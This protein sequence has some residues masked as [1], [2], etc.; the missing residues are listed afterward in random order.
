MFLIKYIKNELHFIKWKG[1]TYDL[2]FLN[3]QSYEYRKWKK[4]LQKVDPKKRV[5]CVVQVY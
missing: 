3:E 2:L 5:L 4:C 1:S